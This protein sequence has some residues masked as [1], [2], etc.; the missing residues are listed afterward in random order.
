MTGAALPY[1]CVPGPRDKHALSLE[2]L[3]LVHT[4]AGK[5]RTHKLLGFKK[6]WNSGTWMVRFLDGTEKRAIYM[7]L[8][9]HPQA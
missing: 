6:V 5:S 1:T 9:G 3:L 2:L 4:R 7:A 8:A